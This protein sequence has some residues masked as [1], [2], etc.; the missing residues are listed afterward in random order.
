[1]RRTPRGRA[2]WLL[3]GLC[4]SSFAGIIDVGSPPATQEED[5]G[6]RA[7]P[8]WS[9]DT[10]VIKVGG[11]SI[12][13]KAVPETLNADALDWFAASLT[14]QLDEYFSSHTPPSS[15]T[16][17]A[18][19]PAANATRTSAFVVIHGAGSFGHHSAKQYGLTSHSEPPRLWDDQH[20]LPVPPADPTQRRRIM[21][22]LAKTHWSV[23][24]LNQHV[25]AAF[26]RH[27]I[28]AIGISPCFILA[29]NGNTNP[30]HRLQELV[31]VT[32][33]AGI[34]PVIHG[35]ACLYG[36]YQA[37]ILSGDVLVQLIA[38]NA[39]G[40]SR[41]IFLTD[42]DGVYTSDPNQDP[43]ATR[44]P[45]IPV[46]ATDGSLLVEGNRL[47]AT[48]SRHGHDVTGGLKVRTHAQTGFG[49]AAGPKSHLVLCSIHP[50]GRRNS[51]VP[52]P[53][54]PLASM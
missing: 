51:P 41:V 33:Q 6:V 44:W 20:T 52:L 18:S 15:A 17:T 26:L 7:T 1:M 40:V 24:T 31:R 25:V 13:H 47:D 27:G 36:P 39:L 22:G 12:T 38:D 32:L 37:G 54:P 5:P 19:C 9:G 49:S 23:K 3:L 35:D 43:D 50:F 53:L 10:V 48:G 29:E 30:G 11:S 28:N 21:E 34:I 4:R 42:V 2:V 8:S 14:S 45:R 46:N 16:H